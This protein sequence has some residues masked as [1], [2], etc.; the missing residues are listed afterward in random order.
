MFCMWRTYRTVIALVVL[1]ISCMLPVMVTAMVSGVAAP[2]FNVPVA[3]SGLSIP[4]VG[5]VPL[6][7]VCDTMYRHIHDGVFTM[8]KLTGTPLYGYIVAQSLYPTLCVIVSAALWFIALPAEGLSAPFLLVVNVI[9]LGAMINAM[10]VAICLLWY[11]RSAD[12]DRFSAQMV[13]VL[14]S[15]G[16]IWLSMW[17]CGQSMGVVNGFVAVLGVGALAVV[18]VLLCNRVFNRRFPRTLIC[19]D[20]EFRIRQS[21]SAM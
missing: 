21:N 19:P 6:T 14:A 18:L 2:G 17:T 5:V 1:L 15:A 13:G 8:V 4:T 3:V 16:A 11:Q 9:M 20:D 10:V 7:L 12:I